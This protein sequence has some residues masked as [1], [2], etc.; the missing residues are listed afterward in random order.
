[1]VFI[2]F[3][4]TVSARRGGLAVTSVLASEVMAAWGTSQAQR[5]S[6]W[7]WWRQAAAGRDRPSADGSAFE[8]FLRRKR[9]PCLALASGNPSGC[10]ARPLFRLRHFV[11]GQGWLVF[12]PT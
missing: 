1:M 2:S 8:G 11:Q 10:G 12:Q 7:C 6:S 4:P 9:R 3:L 5:L